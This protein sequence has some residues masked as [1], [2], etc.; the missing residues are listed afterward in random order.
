MPLGP[1]NFKFLSKDEVPKDGHGWDFVIAKDKVVEVRIYQRKNG[2]VPS[3]SSE[4]LDVKAH[5]VDDSCAVPTPADALAWGLSDAIC[6]YFATR[7]IPS[8]E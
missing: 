7:L 1:G 4:E 2:F 6:A 5:L 8:Y 3:I